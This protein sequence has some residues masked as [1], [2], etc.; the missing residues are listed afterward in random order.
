MLET[1]LKETM[2]SS[3]EQPSLYVVC[4]RG[5]DSQSAVQL[6]HEKG[7]GSA[8]DIVGGLQSWAHDVDPDFPAY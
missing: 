7:F 2:D 8:K 5:N 3:D 6:L 1:S 4:R